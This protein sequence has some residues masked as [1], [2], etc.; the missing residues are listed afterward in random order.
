MKQLI[1]TLLIATTFMGCK[2]DD[3]GIDRTPV[4]VIVHSIT[5]TGFPANNNGVN[6]DVL[7]SN[8]ELYIQLGANGNSLHESGYH[9]NAFSNGSYTFD[10]PNIELNPNGNITIWFYDYDATSSDDYM[11]GIE[12][13]VNQNGISSNP[14]FSLYGFSWSMNVTYEY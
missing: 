8:P 1:L 3:L 7:N 5:V 14:S 10:I 4:N 9:D 6:W 13:D 11:G 2:K 12:F